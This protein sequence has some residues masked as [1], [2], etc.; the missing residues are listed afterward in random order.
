[1]VRKT[2]VFR[3]VLKTETIFTNSLNMIT[4]YTKNIN[5]LIGYKGLQKEYQ[6]SGPTYI[7][8]NTNATVD[9]IVCILQL[10]QVQ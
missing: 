5:L 6:L 1:M 9:Y 3:T 7:Q 10:A 8:T 4:K 2:F